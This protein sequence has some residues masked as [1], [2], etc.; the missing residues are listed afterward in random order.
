LYE[1]LPRPPDGRAIIPDPRN[2]ENLVISGLHCA[3]LLFH[4]AAVEWVRRTTPLTDPAAVFV[5]ARRL[6]TWHYQWVVVHEFLPLV[7]GHALVDDILRRGWRVYCPLRDVPFIPVEFQGACYRMG[8]SMV[9]PSYRANFIGKNGGPFVALL[10][11]AAQ[12]EGSDPDDLSGGHRAPRRFVGWHT[13][14]D[15]GDGNVKPNKRIDTALSSPLFSLP[16]RAIAARDLPTVLPQRTLLR[17][18]TWALPSGQAIAGALG[19]PV[20]SADDLGELRPYGLGLERSTP[21]WYYTLKEAQL[22]AQGL[23]LGP[24]GGRIVAE[25]ILGL[26][27][28]DRTAYLHTAWRPTLPQADGRVSGEFGMVDFLT[29]AGVGAQ[30]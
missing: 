1:D 8:H 10:F 24:V 18:L 11:D 5:A 15:F 22:L 20:L 7:V 25:V 17:H 3:V 2:D 29:F 28:L 14:F 23:T 9:R 4:N 21:L 19:A 6:T 13:F 27:Q 26:L 30:R 16:L 12:S